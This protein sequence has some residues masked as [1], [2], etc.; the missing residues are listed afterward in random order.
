MINDPGQNTPQNNIPSSRPTRKE[1]EAKIKE[2]EAN[3]NMESLIA[4]VMRHDDNQA[5]DPE[6]L[7]HEKINKIIEYIELTDMGDAACFADCFRNKVIYDTSNKEWYLWSNHHWEPDI[8]AQLKHY[9]SYD[10][11]DEYQK[12]ADLLGAEKMFQQKYQTTDY[13]VLANKLKEKTKTIG[14][15]KRIDNVLSLVPSQP[16]MSISGDK[17]DNNIGYLAVE[18]GVIDLRSGEIKDGKQ[19]DYIRAYAPT[20]YRG[21]VEDCPEWK[22]FLSQILNKDQEVIDYLQVLFGYALTGEVKEHVFP[23]LSGEQG[24][25]GKST[26]F[27]TI[28]NVLGTGIVGRLNTDVLMETKRSGDTPQ[29]Q[30]LGMQ[31][32]RIV[33]AQEVNE[34]KSLNPGFIK[35]LSGGDTVSAR[36]LFKDPVTFKPRHTVFL[37]VNAKPHAPHDDA[38]LWERIKVIDFPNRY[39]EDPSPSKPNEHLYDKDLK[40]KLSKERSGILAWLV[41]GSIKYYNNGLIT[42]STVK[43]QANEYRKSEDDLLPFFE[44]MCEI[45]PSSSVIASVLYQAY[46]VW[47]EQNGEKIISNTLFGRKIKGKFEKMKTFDG[48]CYVGVKVKK[49]VR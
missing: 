3:G 19:Q 20:E 15:R 9:V 17:W 10:L 5:S 18:N 35:L 16:G 8:L 46:K 34:N 38:A 31:Y 27:E 40:N 39:V 26:I 21:L 2:A 44:N 42:P 37:S 13:G 47:A 24:R 11:K 6:T 14:S 30:V 48:I 45:D 12:L 33:F 7:T 4:D 29:P 23:I 41:N 25:N 22:K 32:K 36:G 43:N 49:T 28:Q 1:R